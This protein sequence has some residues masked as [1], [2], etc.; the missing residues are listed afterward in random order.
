M[1]YR[2]NMPVNIIRAKVNRGKLSSCSRKGK[3]SGI[4]HLMI[5][6][7]REDGTKYS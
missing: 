5:V 3:W 7:E 4:G 6:L 1:K 2:N